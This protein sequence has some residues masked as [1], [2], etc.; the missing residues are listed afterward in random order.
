MSSQEAAFAHSLRGF[1]GAV[2]RRKSILRVD[3][4]SE[5]A[6]RNVLGRTRKSFLLAGWVEGSDSSKERCHCGP[7]RPCR[8]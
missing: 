3:P 6:E 1:V 8:V 7:I 4:A 5:G 2:I